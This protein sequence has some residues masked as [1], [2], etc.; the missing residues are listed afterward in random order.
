MRARAAHTSASSSL[1]IASLVLLCLHVLRLLAL[2]PSV[3]GLLAFL[4]VLLA[5][6]GWLALPGTMLRRP[7]LFRLALPDPVLR[8]PSMVAFPLPFLY[9][10][11]VRVSAPFLA[12]FAHRLRF[13]SAALVLPALVLLHSCSCTR[14]TAPRSRFRSLLSHTGCVSAPWCTRA[15]ALVHLLPS[16]S[17]RL[18]FRSL[19]RTLLAFPLP[20]ALVHS[21]ASALVSLTTHPL[22]LRSR[23][24]PC[25]VRTLVAFPLPFLC[26]GALALSHVH[27]FFP[28]SRQRKCLFA[29]ANHVCR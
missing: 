24:L 27:P 19:P 5:P 23:F 18:R 22:Q 16:A 25:G 1:L 11:P 10:R 2:C 4:G 6:P 28:P 20:C 14:V 12:V 3:D 13:R 15:S 9:P 8:R 17:R 29:G 26:A 7:P 21:C